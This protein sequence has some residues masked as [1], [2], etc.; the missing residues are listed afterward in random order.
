MNDLPT[1][2]YDLLHTNELHDRLEKSGLLDRV[3]WQSIGIDDFINYMSKPLAHEIA[4]YISE[5]ISGRKEDNLIETLEKVFES[6]ATLNNIIK[7]MYPTEMETL[8]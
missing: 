5:I 1:G 8:Q 3:V 4:I 6:P 7:S 2:L